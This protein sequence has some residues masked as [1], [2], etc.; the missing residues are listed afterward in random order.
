[1]R[2]RP[3]PHP[4]PSNPPAWRKAAL[5][6]AAAAL[7]QAAA[8]NAQWRFQRD[9]AVYLDL[10]RS[11]LEGRGFTHNC[12]PHVK[13]PPGFPAVLAGVGAVFGMPETFQDSFLAMNATVSLAGAG[14]AVLF[15]LLL[16]EL[17]LARSAALWAVAVFA[18]SRTLHYYSAHLM[19]DV[20]FTFLALAVLWAGMRMLKTTGR[21]TWCWCTAA[22]VLAT[23]ACLLRPVGPFLV[24]GLLAALWTRK[25]VRRQLAGVA[26]RTLVIVLTAALPLALWVMRGR[27]V[28]PTTGVH[29]FR[30]KFQAA[31]FLRTLASPVTGFEEHMEGLS[32]AVCGTNL[33]VVVA[34]LLAA[35]MLVG[36]VVVLRRREFM[37]STYAL[38]SMG[39]IVWGG[40]HLDRRYLLPVLPVLVYWLVVGGT[41]IGKHLRERTEFWT[42]DHLARLALVCCLPLVGVNLLRTGKLI[43]QNRHPD[44]YRVTG[45]GRAA[46]YAP[47]C[48]W[49]RRAVHPD[50]KVLACEYETVHYFTRL[51]VVDL[52]PWTEARRLE[53]IRRAI[54]QGRLPYAVSD[55]REEESA[56]LLDRI[57]PPHEQAERTVFTAGKVRILRTGR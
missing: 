27:A 16:R 23:L 10:A 50:R 17:D 52:P 4:A 47:V 35:V 2:I 18:F 13:Y 6:L 36:L 3:E 40:W 11:M 7:L 39:A 19:S 57:I 1:M 45:R 49:L 25:N 42:R 8:L 15:W 29:Y 20:P 54:Q 56:A 30:D 38:L 43:Y 55:E 33:G 34:G 46:D 26:G 28:A 31:R 32:D 12:A 9:S 5:I 22:A 14:A 48:A 44:S 41:A 37:L 51:C 24:V 53:E 21:A